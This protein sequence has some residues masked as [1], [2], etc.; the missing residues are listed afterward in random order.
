[1]VGTQNR[2]TDEWNR[3]ENPEINPHSY[4]K[5]IF[6][7]EVK[8]YNEEKTIYLAICVGKVG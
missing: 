7:K 1:M 8:I 2:N 3:I 6:D 4:G 5:I